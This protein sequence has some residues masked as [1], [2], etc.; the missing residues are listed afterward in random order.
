MGLFGK[1]TNAFVSINSVDLSNHVKTLTINYSSAMLDASAMSN[2]T[3]VNLAGLLDW[4]MTVE[5]VQD[6]AAPAAGSVDS[7]LFPLVGAAAFPI[8]VRPDSAAVGGTNPSFTGNAVLASYN[9]SSGAH[10]ALALATATFQSAGTLAR[11]TT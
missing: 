3:K 7:T 9:P 6:Y 10:G 8:I 5:F 4:S 2:L 11:S 1:F